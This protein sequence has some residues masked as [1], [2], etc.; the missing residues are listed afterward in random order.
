[1]DFIDDNSEGKMKIIG[2]VCRSNSPAHNSAAVALSDG[3][4]VFAAEEEKLVR[5]KH[6]IGL[7]PLTAVNECL[8]F[9]NWRIDD[10][11][12]WA[13][14][15]DYMLGSAQE[16]K[17]EITTS[18]FP[19]LLLDLIPIEKIILVD[20]HL[21]H[22]MSSYILTEK[23]DAAGLVV[24]GNGENRSVSAYDINSGKI[25]LIG[26]I[27]IENSPGLYY[28]SVAEYCGL[29]C[30]APGKLM[31]LASYGNPIKKRLYSSANHLKP[32]AVANK[33]PVAETIG[34][35][36]F[37]D[38]MSILEQDLYPHICNNDTEDIAA[39][40]N[41][42]A[43]AQRDLEESILGLSKIVKSE[44][45]KRTLVAAG[46]VFLNCNINTKLYAESGF[47]EIVI[48]P[49]AHDAGASLGAALEVCQLNGD[50]IEKIQDLDM[51]LGKS[52]SNEESI[53]M[54]K[55]LSVDI[56]SF[57]YEQSIKLA[58]SCLAG[59]RI[60]LFFKGR[61]EFGPRA[62]CNRS[63]LASPAK[64]DMLIRL[65]KLKGREYWRPLAPVIL[66]GYYDDVFET[67]KSNL[68][69][70]MLATAVVRDQYRNKIPAAVHIDGTSRPQII[71]QK[72]SESIVTLLKE[73]HSMTGL[74]CLINTSMN[75]KG[76]PI[77][78]RPLDAI[79]LLASLN[80]KASIFIDGVFATNS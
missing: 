55:S 44:T 46:G 60:L 10:V 19:T 29:G 62:L 75:I 9:C 80:E 79:N 42:A 54:L 48:F 57:D 15:W 8:G 20:H 21:A 52:Y 63:I 13:V 77:C 68:M 37:H 18:V 31:G 51:G 71:D 64:Y 6:A 4:L 3:K 43:T 30:M 58:S 49:A 65:N 5:N 70:H 59:N 14:G 23:I 27:D 61:S 16:K 78:E 35:K 53:A 38:W 41:A 33:F 12:F 22:L 7:F 74:P 24:D 11:D 36:V 28:E 17:K 39:Y 32:A 47:D 34:D 73:H 40:I 76:Q 45:K 2:V 50:T 67:P 26:G 66:D 69:R 72:S 56:K 1:M 25:S